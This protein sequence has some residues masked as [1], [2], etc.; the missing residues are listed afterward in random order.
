M[1]YLEEYLD[2]RPEM[3]S[4]RAKAPARE[5]KDQVTVPSPDEDE[6]IYLPSDDEDD[7]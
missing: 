5:G 6:E 4:M 7:A 2:L 3:I 1:A